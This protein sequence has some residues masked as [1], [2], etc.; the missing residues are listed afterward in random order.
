MRP[1]WTLSVPMTVFP[2]GVHD[3]VHDIFSILLDEFCHT[4]PHKHCR[5]LIHRSGWKF[6]WCVF[7]GN[8]SKM[9]SA[10]IFR[11]KQHLPERKAT[12]HWPSIFLIKYPTP[13]ETVASVVLRLNVI[14]SIFERYCTLLEKSLP[15]QS[16]QIDFSAKMVLTLHLQWIQYFQT[17]LHRSLSHLALHYLKDN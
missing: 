16:C 3:S 14:L 2:Y 8:S 6:I 11:P 9:P 7:T 12:Y 15:C 13:L 17:S 10:V 5:C 4:S 1:V